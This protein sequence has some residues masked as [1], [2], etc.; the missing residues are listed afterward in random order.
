MGVAKLLRRNRI[1]PAPR[2][3]DGSW[4]A[5]VRQQAAQILATDFFTVETVWLKTLSAL[6]FIEHGTREVH[7]AGITTHST[8]DWV[9]Q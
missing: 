2:R 6:F 4:R 5:F 8:G 3:G 1:P 7:L 9:V